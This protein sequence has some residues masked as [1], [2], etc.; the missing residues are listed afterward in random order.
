MLQTALCI[1]AVGK[2]ATITLAGF[3]FEWHI[4]VEN[5][6]EL[7]EIP[8]LGLVLKLMRNCIFCHKGI[9]EEGGEHFSVT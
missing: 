2:L 7:R 4:V 5:K 9:I 8:P 1:A 6:H 3:T